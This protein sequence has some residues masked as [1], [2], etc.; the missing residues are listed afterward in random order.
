M[1]ESAEKSTLSVKA[2]ME[3]RKENA[4][5]ILTPDPSLKELNIFTGEWNVEGRNADDAPF[6]AGAKIQGTESYEWLEGNFFLVYKW[7]RHFGSSEH[8]G[9]GLIGYDKSAH[10][11]VVN[12]YDNLGF[13]RRYNLSFEDNSWKFFG[14]NERAILKFSDD[15]KSF[16][17]KWEILR[18]ASEWKLLCEL[19]ATRIK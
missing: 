19:K 17:E 14:E 3:L 16:A 7:S 15:R 4:P 5:R 11:I 9:I 12:N 18:D 13:M 1:K 10:G 6:I 8:S 2:E